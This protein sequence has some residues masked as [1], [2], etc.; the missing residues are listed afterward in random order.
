[1]LPANPDAVGD[2]T[3]S[4]NYRLIAAV[5]TTRVNSDNTTQPIIQVTAQSLGYLVTY[6]W[7]MTVQT[8][9]VDGPRPAIALKTGQVN[10]ICAHAHV[11]GFRSVQDFDASRLLVNFAV[12]TVG[13]DDGA[14]QDETQYRMDQIG[15]PGVFGAID[16]VWTRLVGV[17]A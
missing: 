13:T 11:I 5:R 16:A 10:Q 3:S 4:E 7:F 17:G 12:I 2:L 8:W 6:T 14:I 1:M 9:D 15:L